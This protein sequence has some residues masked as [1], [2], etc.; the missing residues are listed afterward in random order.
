MGNYLFSF[1]QIMDCGN[2]NVFDELSFTFN[3]N[4]NLITV[5]DLT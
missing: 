2:Q 4:S 3:T 1:A 5:N